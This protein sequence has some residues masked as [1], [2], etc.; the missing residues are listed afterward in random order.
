MDVVQSYGP[1]KKLCKALKSA[2]LLCKDTRKQT[3]RFAPPLTTE[4]SD[5]DWAIGR[6]RDTLLIEARAIKS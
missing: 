2:G 6:I 4:E 1:A 3:V 5:L